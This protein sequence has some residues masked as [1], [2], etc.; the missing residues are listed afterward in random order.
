MCVLYGVFM[1]CGGTHVN[2]GYCLCGM[3]LCVV[4]LCNV[5][6]YECRRV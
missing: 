6:L 4:S 1:I 3:A 2:G 5:W